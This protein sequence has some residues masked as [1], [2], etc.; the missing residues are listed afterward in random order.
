MKRSVQRILIQ[1]T[2]FVNS[3]HAACLFK[4]CTSKAKQETLPPSLNE[5]TAEKRNRN[6]PRDIRIDLKKNNTEQYRKYLSAHETSV[7]W[8]LEKN[9][10][11]D[12]CIDV[13]YSGIKSSKD[14]RPVT[15]KSWKIEGKKAGSSILTLKKI[16]NNT[17]VEQE[18]IKV[19]VIE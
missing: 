10:Q 6:T 1:V 2:L 8:T 17:T 9:E 12:A 15:W 5:N 11:T 19:T 7:E 3:T 14:T 13:Q 16:I 4:C 18:Q